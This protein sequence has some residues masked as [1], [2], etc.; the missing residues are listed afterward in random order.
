[1][2]QLFRPPNI[3]VH[4]QEP[5]TNI[6]M[7]EVLIEIVSLKVAEAIVNIKFIKFF[8]IFFWCHDNNVIKAKLLKNNNF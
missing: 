7:F 5:V 8:E 2:K 6:H 1:M 3:I 4:C